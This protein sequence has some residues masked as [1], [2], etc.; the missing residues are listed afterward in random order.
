MTNPILS[1]ELVEKMAKAVYEGVYLSCDD[2]WEL[3]PVLRKSWCDIV[4]TA[5]TA[6]LPLIQAELVRGMMEPSEGMLRAARAVAL[7]VIE[8]TKHK[9]RFQ[10]MLR[11]Y[12]RSLGLKQKED[13]E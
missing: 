2:W 3:S 9:V 7:G 11:A 6:A 13:G 1:D 4:R 5:L 12:M 10:A 8:D